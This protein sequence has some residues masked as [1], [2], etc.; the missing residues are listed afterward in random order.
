[1]YSTFSCCR[2]CIYF[3]FSIFLSIMWLPLRTCFLGA[4][5][6]LSH[7]TVSMSTYH[8]TE[9]VLYSLRCDSKPGTPFYFLLH[10]FL[11][12]FVVTAFPT[13]FGLTTPRYDLVFQF[14]YSSMFYMGTFVLFLELSLKEM[15]SVEHKALGT[16]A[17]RLIGMQ[18]TSGV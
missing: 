8:Y 15:T 9:I 18:W 12:R 17:V 1:M 16:A 13:N 2:G 14:H 5:P 6:S 10:T 4:S 3:V 11:N 7:A